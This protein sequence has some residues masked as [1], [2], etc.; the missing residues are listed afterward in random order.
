MDAY[1]GPW[2][3]TKKL[4]GSSYDIEHRDT[5]KVSKKHALYLSPYP[6]EL[7]LFLSLDGAD[8]RFGQMN[9]PLLDS[10]Y[11]NAGLTGFET[12]QPYK[13]ESISLLV[14]KPDLMFPSLAELN[15]E[16]DDLTP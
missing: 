5:K 11:S 3:I 16:L 6:R 7:L 14:I 4:H 15:A 1:T 8:N 13:E 10:P 2:R 12:S 9:A